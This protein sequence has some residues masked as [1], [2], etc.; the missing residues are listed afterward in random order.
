MVC[1]LQFN[2]LL[3]SSEVFFTLANQ[4]F[5]CTVDSL[6]LYS[7]SSGPVSVYSLVSLAMPVG[8]IHFPNESHSL[9]FL[10]TC[11]WCQTSEPQ[12]V[13]ELLESTYFMTKDSP[14]TNAYIKIWG[15]PPLKK[16]QLL[17]L[18]IFAYLLYLPPFYSLVFRAC[19]KIISLS[20]LFSEQWS[21]N[22]ILA[23]RI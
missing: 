22:W 7:F 17:G 9:T 11:R 15:S 18:R 8:T 4:Q 12:T 13:L 16:T 19:S 20:P 14:E 5:M 10:S 1:F 21:R 2:Y 6:L 3:V 23:W